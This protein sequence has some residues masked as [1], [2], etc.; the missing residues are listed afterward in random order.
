MLQGCSLEVLNGS[1]T[2]TQC[3]ILTDL[4]GKVEKNDASR[5]ELTKHI[6]VQTVRTARQ[7]GANTPLQDESFCDPSAIK[8][9]ALK[10]VSHWLG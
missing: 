2:S 9:V 1:D 4:I 5:R 3:S 8:D 6:Q 7:N 10:R